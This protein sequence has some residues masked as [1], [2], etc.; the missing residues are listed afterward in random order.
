MIVQLDFGPVL[1]SDV[2]VIAVCFWLRHN[3]DFN[4]L[5]W[6]QR[7]PFHLH[8]VQFILTLEHHLRALIWRHRWDGGW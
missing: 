7:P 1:L 4:I 8:L 2:D 6:R 3:V 5:I